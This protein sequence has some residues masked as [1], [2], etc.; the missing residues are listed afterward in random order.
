VHGSYLSKMIDHCDTSGTFYYQY[1]ELPKPCKHQFATP[2]GIEF[3]YGNHFIKYSDGSV[4]LHVDLLAETKDSYHH[5]E[6]Q[7]VAVAQMVSPPSKQASKQ[8]SQPMDTS[9]HT[10]T[11]GCATDLQY[12]L[13][14]PEPPMKRTCSNSGQ[15]TSMHP[16]NHFTNMGPHQQD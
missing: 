7:L 10:K 12:T 15:E 5:V 16:L 9:N 4:F 13:D 8:A 14:N 1:I 2:D 6:L 3:F 11:G